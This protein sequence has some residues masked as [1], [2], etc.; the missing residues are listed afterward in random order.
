M[1]MKLAKTRQQ[2]LTETQ[3][4]R[5]RLAQAEETLRA[6]RSSEVDALVVSGV[7]GERVFT[8]EGANHVYRVLI[9]NMSE[10]ALTLTAE[11][12]ILYANR[13]FA[14]ML[15]TPLEK[16]IGSTIHTWIAPDSQRILH[17]LLRKGVDERRREELP[18]TASDGTQ[19]PVYLSANSLLME[20]IPDSFCL[21]VTD[22]TEQKRNEAIVAAEKEQRAAALYARSLIEASLDP[23]VTISPEGKITDV[24][25]ATEE[26]TGIV[27][28]Q[29]VGT[30]FADYFTEPERA[31]AGYKQVLAQGCM[32][33]YPLTLRHRSGRTTNVLYN[34]AAYHNEAGRLHGVF[35]AAR[36]ITERKNQELKIGRLNR[37]LSVLSGINSAIVRIRD[38]QKLFEEACRIAVEHGNFGMAW[39]SEFD[40]ATLEVTPVAWAGIDVSEH[41]AGWKST[42]RADVPRGQG[43]IGHAIRGKS[44]SVCNDIAAEPDVGSAKRKEAIRRGYRSLVALPLF[45]EGSV[46]GTLTLYAR[47]PSFFNEEELKLLRELASDISFALEFIKQQH[48]VVRLSRI[49]AVMSGVSSLIVRISDRPELFDGACRIAVEQGKLVMAWIGMLDPATQDVTPVAK[50]GRDD[51]YLEQINFSLRNDVTGCRTLTAEALT[52]AVPVVCNDISVDE[53]MSRWRDEALKRG[54]RSAAFFP[55][56]IEQRPIG[57][58]VLYAPEPG[59]FDEQEMKLLNELADNISFALQAIARQEKLDKLS[60]IRAVSGEINAAIVRIR[61]RE[62]L[63]KETCRIAVEHGKFELVWIASLDPEKQEVRPVAWAGFSPDTAHAVSWETINAARGTIADAIRTRRAA[64][65]NDIDAD[66]PAGTLRRDA[67]GKGCLSTVCMPLVVDDKVVAL[68]SLFAPGRGFFDPDELAL[69]DE[70]AADVSFALAYI[71]NEE[72][73]N[74]LAYYDALTGLPN[75]ALFDDRMMQCLRTAGHEENK[76]ALVL[77]DLERFRAI[78]DTLGRSAAD[79]LLKLVAERLQGVI[80]DRDSLARVHADVFAALFTAIKDEAEIARLVEEKIIG[81]LIQPFTIAGQ[82]VRVSAKAGVALFPGDATGPDAL[83]IYAEVA[84]K[85]A[86]TSGERYL[87]YAPKMNAFVAERLKLENKLQ[88]AMEREEFVLFYQPKVDLLTERVTGLEALIRWNDPDAGLVLPSL[89]IPLLEE[90]GMIIEVGAWALKWAVSEYAAWLETGLRPP[91]ISVNVSP[92]QL[93]RKDFVA[94]VRQAIATAGNPDHGLDLEITESVMME[95]IDSNIVKLKAVRELG[96]AIA[97]DDFGTGHSSLRYLARLPITTL[98]IDRAFV[99]DMTTNPDDMAIVSVTISLAH[100]LNLKVVAEGV[101]AAEQSKLLRLLKCDEIQGFLFSKPVPAAQVPLL[102]ERGREICP[103]LT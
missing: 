64:T 89:F 37:V 34:A 98:K 39:I 27:R 74:Y 35:A 56:L 31:S 20:A 97:I 70:L 54:Y 44:T 32:R 96:V 1:P 87:F 53:R 30:D 46:W 13:R 94:M 82:G 17:A 100:N 49:E 101:E 24:N 25:K 6:I 48:K 40:P 58:F 95:D 73:L 12:L 103:G 92:L 88:R 23:L 78:N 75:R 8:L 47:E 42:A 79:N 80:F 99:Q 45:V 93:K 72:K 19:V 60:R 76:V 4:V 61:E 15:K 90:T 86:K 10:G 77:I 16:V 59:A 63:L 69:L 81:S 83:F 43:V 71:A 41:V 68:C 36:D 5:A 91:R 9:E 38:R 3:D 11:G 7:G 22:L 51:G 18:L 21:V 85:Q 55:L 66:V 33:D 29:L 26:V 52:R 65:R 62:S 67:I 50:A 2:L 102:L 84:L 28:D 57:I 14:E